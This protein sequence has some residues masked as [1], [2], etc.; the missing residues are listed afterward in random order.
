[1]AK[2][3]SGKPPE[4]EAPQSRKDRYAVYDQPYQFTFREKAAYFVKIGVPVVAGL[5]LVALLASLLVEGFRRETRPDQ[6]SQTEE[7]SAEQFFIKAA[8]YE[9]NNEGILAAEQLRL[10]IRQYPNTEARRRAEEL[11]AK[12]EQGQLMFGER[13]RLDRPPT[14]GG[15]SSARP[16]D[17]TA[18]ASQRQ[19]VDEALSKPAAIQLAENAPVQKLPTGFRPQL[20][21]QYHVSGWPAEIVCKRDLAEMVLIPSGPFTMGDARGTNNERPERRIEQGTFYIDKFEVTRAQY[22]RF[23][24]ANPAAPRLTPE[25]RAVL[26]DPRVPVVGVSHPDA[27]RYCAWAGRTLPTESQWEKAARGTQGFRFPWGNDA[28][29]GPAVRRYR[30]IERIL[31]QPADRSPFAVFDTAGNAA[32]WCAD[33]YARDAYRTSKIG[34]PDTPTNEE[35]LRTIRGGSRQG[36]VTWRAGHP[37]TQGALWLGFRGALVIDPTPPQIAKP[38]KQKPVAKTKPRPNPKTQT[39]RSRRRPGL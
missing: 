23:L 13:I 24:Q 6:A 33:W 32:E 8:D 2:K 28:R 5:A 3:R 12:H 15:D 37:E 39:K 25:A 35:R 27:L 20:G 10:L 22:D 17:E 7:T 26:G 38:P 14:P 11:L 30:A 9:A 36:S 16:A 34:G 19:L 31:S 18:A 21:T 29:Q 1:M 4:E